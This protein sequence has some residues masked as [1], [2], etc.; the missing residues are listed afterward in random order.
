MT[1]FLL[2]IMANM[3]ADPIVVFSSN[4]FT[5]I[6]TTFLSLQHMLYIYYSIYLINAQ[7][8]IQALI[9]FDSEVNTI[10]QLY[11]TKLSLNIQSTNIKPQKIDIS[12]LK[13]LA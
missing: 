3:E 5:S 11:T 13:Y 8:K 7:D 2:I 12:I 9:D 6:I 10:I 4:V 1:T